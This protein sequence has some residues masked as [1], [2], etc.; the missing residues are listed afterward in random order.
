MHFHDKL[1]PEWFD[2][3]VV[4]HPR[5]TWHK[6]RAVTVWLKP[7]GARNEAWDVSVYNL[8][9]AHQLGLHKWSPLDWGKLRTKL[10]PPTRD[11]FATEPMAMPERPE[12]FQPAVPAADIP[13]AP[14]AP[15]Q[16]SAQPTAPPPVQVSTPVPYTPPRTPTNARRIYSRGIS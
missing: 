2:Q 13:A 8:A 1:L 9:I 5:T 7:N 12:V 15:V 4:E 16:T 11:M 10:V 6:G 14:V 3:M